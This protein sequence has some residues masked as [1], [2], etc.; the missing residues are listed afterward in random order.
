M[1]REHKL[2]NKT[3]AAW[4]VI[5]LLSLYFANFFSNI[6]KPQ[7]QLYLDTDQINQNVVTAFV[8]GETPKT[9]EKE[10]DN[11]YRAEI[12]VDN[13][14]YQIDVTTS[15]MQIESCIIDGTEQSFISV[16]RYTT[17]GFY[18]NTYC[19]RL[20]GANPARAFVFGLFLLVFVSALWRIFRE[21]T[22]S[23]SGISVLT[24]SSAGFRAI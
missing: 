22:Q 5:L 20:K 18:A 1:G 23:K 7:K 11:H 3:C 13:R 2:K 12:S 14:S 9:L 21:I 4:I 6:L 19:I 8:Y 15:G 24:Y 10:S 17:S 16:A